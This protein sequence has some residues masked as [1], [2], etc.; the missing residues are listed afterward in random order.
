MRTPRRLTLLL[1]CLA[2]W[3][4]GTL[5]ASYGQATKPPAAAAPAAAP[6]A[7]VLSREQEKKLTPAQKEALRLRRVMDWARETN[8]TQKQL[9]YR[10]YEPVIEGCRRDYPRNQSFAQTCREK[11]G[12][13]AQR[14]QDR[15]ADSFSKA[16]KLF[17]ELAKQNQAVVRAIEAGDAQALEAACVA[18]PEIETQIQQLTER[19]VERDWLLPGELQRAAAPPAP[20][21]PAPAK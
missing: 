20:P 9:L 8:P 7:P 17:Q 10:I 21:A 4:C 12:D 19:R 16:A 18:I 3:L 15:S 2:L 11:A 13:A 6:A 1:P 14:G 5:A